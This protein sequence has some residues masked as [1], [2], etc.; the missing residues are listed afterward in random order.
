MGQVKEFLEYLLNVIKIWVIIQPWESALIVRNGKRIKKVTKGIYFKLPYFDSVFVQ[1]T[2]LRVVSM[3]VQNITTKDG[4]T[5]TINSAMGY[6]ISDID[7]LYNTLYHPETT[8]SNMTMGVISDILTET[9]SNNISLN[10]IVE[11]TKK[12]LALDDYGIT[13]KYFKFINFAMVGTYRIIQDQSWI[14]EGL[15]MDDK[16]V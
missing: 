14:G 15:L 13:L 11:E 16:R 4:K 12:R 8:I 5:V 7:L 2:R 10:K 6:I 9:E 1:E 3:P